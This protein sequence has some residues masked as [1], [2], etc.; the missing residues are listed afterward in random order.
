MTKTSI[1]GLLLLALLQGCSE[2]PKSLTDGIAKEDVANSLIDGIAKEDEVHHE[3]IGITGEESA[4]F[5][6][7][8]SLSASSATEDLIRLTKH[9]NLTVRCYAAWGLIDKKFER[10]DSIFKEFLEEP[11]EVTTYSGCV[12]SRDC[13]SSVLY[14]RYWNGIDDTKE[15]SDRLLLALDHIILN[16]RNVDW[17][18]TVRALENRKYPRD[19]N[20]QIERLA[21]V[22]LNKDAIFYLLKWYPTEYGA[23]AMESLIG[24]LN[25]TKFKNTGTSDYFKVASELL[26]SGDQEAKRAVV[27]KL[28]VDR[29]WTLDEK[30]FAPLLQR[31][32]INESATIPNTEQGADD[33]L[34]A[35]LDAKEP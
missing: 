28:K 2:D 23:K 33:Q 9:D 14:H 31:Y 29:H 26:A 18:L 8:L 11:K 32:G 24:Y 17:L 35:R 6:R 16:T 4:Q 3:G 27:S 1:L 34:P 21:F 12:K 5:R 15:E 13:I 10:L 25:K 20:P 22:E 7:Y 19:L 30:I